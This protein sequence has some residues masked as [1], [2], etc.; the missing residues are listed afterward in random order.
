[1]EARTGTAAWEE[2]AP[3]GLAADPELDPEPDPAL[4][5]PAVATDP[6]STVLETALAVL[7]G[8]VSM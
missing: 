4:P 3:V 1:M 6:L 2:A 8:A 7:L 5:T